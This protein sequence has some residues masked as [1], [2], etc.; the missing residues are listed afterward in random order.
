MIPGIS[1]LW[2]F[3][4]LGFRVYEGLDSGLKGLGFEVWG[5]E[6]LDLGLKGLGL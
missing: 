1:G 5:Y 2:G 6:G 3:R 4:G